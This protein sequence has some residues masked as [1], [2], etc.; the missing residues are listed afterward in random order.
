MESVTTTSNQV[1]ARLSIY[2]LCGKGTKSWLRL[3]A[4]ILLSL[5][6]EPIIVDFGFANQW[7]LTS[8]H[9]EHAFQTNLSW[10]TPEYLSPERATQSM[11]DERLSDIWYVYQFAL[12]RLF[13]L[14]SIDLALPDR[15]LGVTMYEIVVGRTPFEKDETEGMLPIVVDVT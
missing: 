12:Q 15:S 11:H 13:E 6:N 14:R 2:V 7:V 8:E 9:A 4:N 1:C 10:G 3:K 5:N